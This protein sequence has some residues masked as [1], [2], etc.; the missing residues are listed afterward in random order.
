MKITLERNLLREALQIAAAGIPTN[1]VLPALNNIFFKATG[2]EIRLITTNL[3]VAV[4]SKIDFDTAEGIEVL[5]PPK[6]APIVDSLS[7]DEVALDIN[8]NG[9]RGKVSITGGASKFDLAVQDTA[10]FPEVAA[11]EAAGEVVTF[12]QKELKA[13]LKQVIF[14]VS[15]D[16]S[17]PAFQGVLFKFNQDGLIVCSSD[18]FRLAYKKLEIG[19]GPEKSLLVPGKSLKELIRLLSDEDENVSVFSAESQVVFKTDKFTFAARVLN[20]KYPDISGVI[21]S[22]SKTTVVASTRELGEVVAR[23]SLLADGANH[24]IQLTLDD[25]SGDNSLEVNSVTQLG[26]AKEPVALERKEGENVQLHV[27]ARFLIDA[28]KAVAGSKTRLCFNGSNGPILVYDD[29]DESWFNLIL[30]VRVG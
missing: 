4:L 19:K 16:G 5:L 30:P 12:T 2:S 23:A 22:S 10:N 13:L 6:F 25:N 7:G 27:N 11:H 9:E 28:L 18:A 26:Q 29:E 1:T 8:L 15:T 20:E 24:S 17:R 3:E 14:C 21:P